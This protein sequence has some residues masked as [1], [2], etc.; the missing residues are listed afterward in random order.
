VAVRDYGAGVPVERRDR[1][2]ERF[3]QAHA[4]GHRGGLGLGLFISRQIAQLHGGTLEAE[5][6]DAGGSRFVLILPV[7]DSDHLL[8]SPSGAAAGVP[9]AL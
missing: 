1:L 8:G 5:F 7:A 9:A 6:P 2:F 4:E 3:Y